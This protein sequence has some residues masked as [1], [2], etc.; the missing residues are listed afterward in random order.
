MN[1]EPRSRPLIRW[2]LWTVGGMAVVVS[3][4]FGTLFVLDNIEYKSLKTGDDLR[5]E[6]ARLIMTALEKYRSARGT[7]PVFPPPHDVPA[8][9]LKNE[10]VKAGYLRRIPEDPLWPEN[11]RYVSYNG[12]IYGLLFRLEVAKGNIP[13]TGQCLT[14]VGTSGNIWW[15]PPPNCPF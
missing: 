12:K 15:G 2:L 11:P 4:F 13:A 7:Y 1:T 3:F 10:L 8:A 6:H 9:D 14:G 5:A